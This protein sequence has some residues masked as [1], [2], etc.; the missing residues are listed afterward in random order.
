MSKGAGTIKDVPSQAGRPSTRAWTAPPAVAAAWP[1]GA[2]RC[3]ERPGTIWAAC[4]TPTRPAEVGPRSIR[5]DVR[6]RQA[7]WGQTGYLAG[8][9]ESLHP[10]EGLDRRGR[11]ART[12]LAIADH[13]NVRQ[14]LPQGTGVSAGARG[15]E[16]LHV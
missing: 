13:G 9:I 2:G 7:G 12:E 3:K 16:M 15:E 10:P 11:Q 8:Q 6:R 14:H 5:A 4:V 1:R